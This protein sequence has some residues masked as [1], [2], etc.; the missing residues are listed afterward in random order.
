MFR[1]RGDYRG[2]ASFTHHVTRRYAEP[3][4]RVWA[5]LLLLLVA[6]FEG[7]VTVEK[8]PGPQGPP[9][10]IVKPDF[11]VLRSQ[12]DHSMVIDL[13]H[14]DP[15]TAE[16]AETNGPNGTPEYGI[17]IRTTDEGSRRLGRWSRDN[18]GRQVGIYLDGRLISAPTLSSEVEDAVFIGSIATKAEAEAVMAR[19]RRGGA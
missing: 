18:I 2:K 10:A 14:L 12:T 17:W 6:C 9:V 16:L 5:P 19:L 1:L 4:R 13:R 8:E 15:R 11:I 3:M 7:P